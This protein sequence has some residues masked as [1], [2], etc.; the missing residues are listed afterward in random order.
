MIRNAGQID[1]HE[2]HGGDERHG[3]Q[4]SKTLPRKRPEG[5]SASDGRIVFLADDD[6]TQNEEKIDCQEPRSE[7]MQPEDAVEVK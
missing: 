4:A 3:I 2:Q 1:S 6:A 5:Q 7:L